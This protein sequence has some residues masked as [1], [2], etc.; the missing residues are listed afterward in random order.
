MNSE[1]ENYD[2]YI[3]LMITNIEFIVIYAINY[4]FN[5]IIKII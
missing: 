2:F 3:V 5:D 1:S 4:V